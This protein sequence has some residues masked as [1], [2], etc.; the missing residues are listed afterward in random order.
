[1]L[2]GLVVTVSMAAALACAVT[3]TFMTK[4]VT[5]VAGGSISLPMSNSTPTLPPKPTPI[6]TSIP[7]PTST[8]TSAPASIWTPPS[9][10]LV[11]L[12]SFDDL[13]SCV[14]N[15]VLRISSPAV[16]M[17]LSCSI[18]IALVLKMDALYAKGR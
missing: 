14:A 2:V 13:G 12:P 6:P 1:M 3:S 11:P 18:A 10:S 15:G 16:A 7:T 9:P 8:P 17:S 4:V 5:P